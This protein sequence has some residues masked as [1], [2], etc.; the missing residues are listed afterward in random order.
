MARPL[1]TRGPQRSGRR[2]RTLPRMPRPI[3]ARAVLAGVLALFAL[4]AL[5]LG[6]AGVGSSD[7]E[8]GAVITG[9]F[10]GPITVEFTEAVAE[11]S[12]LVLVD[13]AGTELGVGAFDASMPTVIVLDLDAPIGAGEYTI[14]WT[15]RSDDGHVER[16]TIGFSV[17]DAT[18]GPTIEP[19]ATPSAPATPAP[20]EIP[21]SPIPSPDG[22]GGNGAGAE[23]IVPIAAV[24]LVLVLGF[25]VLRRR[26]ATR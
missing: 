12:G 23:V 6:H 19:S 17:V 13:P 9:P 3:I 14:R 22:G 26:G 7:P 25:F 4:P 10:E 8:A 5:A 24:G 18:S 2:V 20:T 15:I 21:A 16:G 11:G 1:M